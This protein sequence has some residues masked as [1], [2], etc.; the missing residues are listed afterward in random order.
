MTT[1]MPGLLDALAGVGLE[2][3]VPGRPNANAPGV[4]GDLV[5][6]PLGILDPLLLLVVLSNGLA[7]W[8]A[9]G[10][11]GV[12]SELCGLRPLPILLPT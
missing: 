5:C 1:A 11:E 12:G 7:A 8:L 3:E 4:V 10:L 2:A 6:G 9:A